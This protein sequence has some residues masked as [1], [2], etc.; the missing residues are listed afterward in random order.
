MFDHPTAKGDGREDL[1][2]RFLAERVGTT[3]GVSKAEVVDSE[4]NTSGELD[5]VIFD[6]SVASCL[7]WS[8]S[9]GNIQLPRS[10][11]DSTRMQTEPRM[12]EDGYGVERTML[13][14]HSFK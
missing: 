3:F 5:V 12:H 11:S 2:R 1:L 4:G 13:S 9:S 7:I 14:G 6:Q 10:G 8:V